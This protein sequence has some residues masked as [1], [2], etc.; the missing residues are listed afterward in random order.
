M[1]LRE[2]GRKGCPECLSGAGAP[3]GKTDR[4][5]REGVPRLRAAELTDV[6]L[7]SLPFGNQLGESLRVVLPGLVYLDDRFSDF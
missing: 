7:R 6:L 2:S 1:A 3:P 4:R 5:Y